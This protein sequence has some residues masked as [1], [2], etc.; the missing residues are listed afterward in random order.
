[1]SKTGHVWNVTTINIRRSCPRLKY[2]RSVWVASCFQSIRVLF[3]IHRVLFFSQACLIF[4]P[5][6]K[7]LIW[8]TMRQ[9][10]ICMRRNSDPY[11][12]LS[13]R[14]LKRDRHVLFFLRRVWIFEMTENQ[15]LNSTACVL[16][17]LCIASWIQLIFEWLRL[18]FHWNLQR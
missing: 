9:D 17:S 11:H 15:V 3:S 4:V 13:D 8:Y 16:N 5:R 1:M 6:L 12:S 2:D 14:V 7:I 18:G 10:V